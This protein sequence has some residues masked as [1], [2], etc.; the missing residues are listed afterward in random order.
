MCGDASP[1]S[2]FC[3][4]AQLLLLSYNR[5][6]GVVICYFLIEKHSPYPLNYSLRFH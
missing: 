4:L 6:Q 3:Y 5:K 1:L 2:R